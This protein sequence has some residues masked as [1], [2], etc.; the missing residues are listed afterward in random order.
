MKTKNMVYFGIFVAVLV[1][2]DCIAGKEPANFWIFYYKSP[3][4]GQSLRQQ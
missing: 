2:T 1:I 4:P 3:H